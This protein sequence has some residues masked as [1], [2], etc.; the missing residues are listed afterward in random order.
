MYLRLPHHLILLPK[1]QHTHLR[2]QP[3]RQLVH[4]E[5]LPQTTHLQP[6]NQ[7]MAD[8]SPEQALGRPGEPGSGSPRPAVLPAASPAAVA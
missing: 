3:V 5:Q 6:R 7:P 4:L 8:W 2:R 1:F